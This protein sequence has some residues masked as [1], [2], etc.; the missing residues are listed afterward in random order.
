[1]VVAPDGSDE[2][3][4]G[5]LTRPYATL[6]KAVGLVRPGQT[7]ALRGGTYRPS[8]PVTIDTDGTAARPVLL[9]AY[10]GERPVLDV[11]AVPEGRWAVTQRADH[12]TVRGL[13]VRGSSSHAW[14]CSGCAHDVFDGLTMHHNAESGLVLRDA[15]TVGNTVVDSDFHHNRQ[16]DGGGTGLA[17]V[18]G[19]GEGNTVRDCRAWDN[20][21]DGVDLGGFTDPVVLDGNWAYRN[22][23]GFTLGGGRTRAPVAHVVRNNAAWDNGGHG[24]TDDG[25]TG[26]PVLERNSAYRNGIAG[27]RVADAAASLVRNAAWSNRREAE[28]GPSVRS[29]GN[30]WDEDG[31][32]VPLT[33]LRSDDPR[34]AEGARSPDGALPST[35]FLRLRDPA[36]GVG[37]PMT[38]AGRAPRPRVTS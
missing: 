27:F 16:G 25:N 32:S 4:D 20:G 7:I 35:A 23:D 17:V 21:G 13:E 6:G 18:F 34:G 24:F 26:S 15:G 30:T 29:W 8:E 14:V 12:W 2:R 31:P 33:G 3:G 10:R 11:S 28:L 22:G 19:A 38:A 1:I 9:T 37:A 36:A 5:S